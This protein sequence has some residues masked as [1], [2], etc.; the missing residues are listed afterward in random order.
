MTAL[1]CVTRCILFPK[2]KIC[3]VSGTRS[4]ANEVLSKIEDDFMKNYGWGSDNLRREVTF[5]TVGANKAVIE[6]ANG[7]WIKVVTA[8]DNAR[9]SRANVIIVDEFRVVDKDI[10]D[11]VIRRFLA[12]PRQPKYLEDPKYSQLQERNK[13]IYM[14][15]AWWMDSWAYD[16]FKSYVANM[17]DDKKKYFVCSL[18]YQVSIMEGLLSREQIQ[19]EMSEKDFDDM[20]F[21]IDFCASKTC[22]TLYHGVYVVTQRSYDV[23]TVEL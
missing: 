11:T 2:T 9:G 19:D 22:L 16:K 3:I 10:I 6:F 18:P 4:Q 14:S 15:S 8:S 1:F 20:K 7:S 21:C 23:L 12:A 13:E 17:L 5:H